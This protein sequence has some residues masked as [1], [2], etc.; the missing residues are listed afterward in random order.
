MEDNEEVDY[1]T[2]HD[3]V[4]PNVKE[5]LEKGEGKE[6]GAEEPAKGDTDQPSLPTPAPTIKSPQVDHISLICRSLNI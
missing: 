2:F 5:I 4:W 3:K 1:E 6:E